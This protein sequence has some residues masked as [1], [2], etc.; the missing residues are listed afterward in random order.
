MKSYAPPPDYNSAYQK[1]ASQECT[2]RIIK[3]F[4]TW[5][6]LALLLGAKGT[7]HLQGL[8]KYMYNV[9]AP[10][11]SKPW[12]LQGDGKLFYLIGGTVYNEEAKYLGSVE[13]GQGAAIQ[14]GRQVFTVNSEL[15]VHRFSGFGEPGFPKN[16]AGVGLA[17]HSMQNPVYS[18]SLA[19]DGFDA[20]YVTGGS[21]QFEED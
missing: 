3:S 18:F 11:I 1:N 15:K 8:S 2:E 20:L 9:G 12:K 6:E 17:Q 5:C 13:N 16:V 7:L 10:R 21:T 19:S 4:G 14:V